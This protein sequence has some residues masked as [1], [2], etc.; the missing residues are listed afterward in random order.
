MAVKIHRKKKKP[1]SI[2]SQQKRQHKL[3]SLKNE[4]E[5]GKISNFSQVFAIFSR[6]PLSKELG[7]PFYTFKTKVSN[8]G[9]FTNNELI[10]FA[11]LINVDIDI[12]VKFIYQQITGLKTKSKDGAQ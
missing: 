2:E 12:I 11:E 10:R 6:S 9:E 5:G 4:F 7:I 3:N 8:P 1:Q